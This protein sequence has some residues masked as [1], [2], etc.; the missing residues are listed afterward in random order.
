VL[1]TLADAMHRI[2]VRQLVPG[3]AADGERPN[4]DALAAQLRPELVQL[5]YQMALNGRRDLHLAPSP[6]AGFEMS[7][8]R[9][10]A[11]RP[12]EGG[13]ETIATGNTAP[14]ASGAA[15]A[16]AALQESAPAKAAPATTATPKPA[17]V[18]PPR[19]APPAATPVDR[20]IPAAT[21]AMQ[22]VERAAAPPP[23]VAQ[24]AAVDMDAERWLEVAAHC[25][26]RGPAREL[27]AHAGYVDYDG[28]VLRL[29]LPA[30]DDHLNTPAL[31]KSLADALAPAFGIAPQIRFEAAPAAGETLHQRSTRER[32]ERQVA[33]ETAFVNDPD[34]QR[35]MQR[36]AKLVPDSIRPFDDA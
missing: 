9:M 35:L 24:A 18:A 20:A 33:A 34:V 16:R 26:L 11:F 30:A 25:Q 23:K 15:A 22:A 1:D 3:V 17:A 8:L 7:V 14:R 28:A 13:G 31:V 32:G 12:V 29:S 27:L 5:W 2:Q 36:G 19:P 4:L 10:L 6:R 21:I